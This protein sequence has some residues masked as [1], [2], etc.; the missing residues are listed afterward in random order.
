[1]SA[2]KEDKN[3]VEAAIPNF[4]ELEAMGRT[5]H[6]LKIL[7][8]PPFV[9]ADPGPLGLLCF[10]MTTCTLMFLVAEWVPSHEAGGYVMI[11]MGYAA[12]YGGVGQFVAGILELIKGNTFGGTAFASYGC[13]WM[14]WFGFNYLSMEFPNVGNPGLAHKGKALY[15]GLWG[16]LTFGFLIV[17]LRKNFCLVTIF[18]TLVITFGLLAGG[19][20]DARSAQAA[21]YVGGFCGLSAIYAGLAFMYQVNGINMPGTAPI[22]LF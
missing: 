6:N 17:T 20:Y 18:S 10:G 5:P 9:V 7:S 1:M 13:F 14:G 16:L 19:E 22:Q 12:F 3:D 8:T 4:L 21:G 11:A 2:K 15:S